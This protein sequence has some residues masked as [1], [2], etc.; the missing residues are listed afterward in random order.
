MQKRWQ[1]KTS[2]ALAIAGNDGYMMNT[3]MMI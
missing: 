2:E 3:L 1:K